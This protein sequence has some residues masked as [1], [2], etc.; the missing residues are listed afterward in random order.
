MILGWLRARLGFAVIS[1]TI[2]A[3]KD[4]VLF[5][6]VVLAL[7]ILCSDCGQYCIGLTALLDS[8]IK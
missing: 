4:L 5:G 8:I 7:M 3:C 1:A 2:C 6:E